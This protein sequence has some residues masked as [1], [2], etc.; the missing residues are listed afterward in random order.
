MELLIV[1]IA[2]AFLAIAA[3]LGFSV[4]KGPEIP[5]E[6]KG[7]ALK[8]PDADMLSQFKRKAAACEEKLKSLEMDFEAASLELKQTKEKEK[9]LLTEKSKITFDSEQYEKFKKD[10]QALKIELTGKEVSLEK[11]ISERRKQ[12]ME[13]AL[14]RQEHDSSKKKNTETQDAYRKSQTMVETLTKE[15]QAIKSVLNEQRKIVDEHKEN[16]VGGEWVSRP[17]FEKIERELR[18]KEAMI[19]RLLSLKKDQ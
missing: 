19:Q 5:E 17:E 16:K 11:E 14:I 10:F 15:L 9:L 6:K 18:E 13:L 3:A 1:F 12:G 8:N 2:V 4:F 7:G